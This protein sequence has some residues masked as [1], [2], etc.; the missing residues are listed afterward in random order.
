MSE[1]TRCDGISSEAIQNTLPQSTTSP[2][3]ESEEN[4]QK[5]QNELKES[6]S[7][8]D[9]QQGEFQPSDLELLTFQPIGSEVSVSVWDATP[10]QFDTYVRKFAK[11]FKNVNTEVWPHADRL[12]FLNQLYQYCQDRWLVFPFAGCHKLKNDAVNE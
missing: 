2:L 3:L 4:E 12:H 8:E 1:Q 5:R 7:S 11:G 9:E 6:V 10:E